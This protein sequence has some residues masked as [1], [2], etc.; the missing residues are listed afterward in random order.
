MQ[1]VKHSRIVIS[2]GTRKHSFIECIYEYPNLRKIIHL[3]LLNLSFKIMKQYLLA[4]ILSFFVFSA[5][6][7]SRVYEAPPSSST[8]G[9]VPWISD[10]KMEDCVKLYNEAKWLSSKIDRT[11][12]NQYS[13]ESVDSYNQEVDKHSRMINS[14]NKD[15][16]GKQS[17]SAYKAAQKLNSQNY[18]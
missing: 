10:E 9:H 18:R 12:V 6:A 15:C 1:C 8:H 16:A 13:Q 7:Q 3:T 17:E 11:N 14:F 4:F 5:H 2:W